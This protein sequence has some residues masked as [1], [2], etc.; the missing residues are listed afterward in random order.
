MAFSRSLG[1]GIVLGVSWLVAVGCGDSSNKKVVSGGESGE[2]GEATT[3]GKAS[4]GSSNNAGKAGAAGT[5][6]T[7][8]DVAGAGGMGISGDAGAGPLGTA[9]A[10]GAA[11]AGAGGAAP[12]GALS[13]VYAC[14]VDD[15]CLLPGN[16]TT[17]KC[18]PTTKRCDDRTLLCET[19]HECFAHVDSWPAGCTINDDCSFG[20]A[21]VAF[22]GTGFCAPLPGADGC[23]PDDI[24]TMSLFEGG[25]QQVCGSADARCIAGACDLGCS[26][27]GCSGGD[28][29]T[30]EPDSGV[31]S[32]ETGADCDSGVC[33]AGHC[34]PAPQCAT[35]DDCAATADD[36]GLDV[37]VDGKCGC[38]TSDTCI[39]G[40][41]QN[42]S[43][44]CE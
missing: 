38:A 44:V 42:S 20:E 43:T 31:C 14:Q 33:T 25:E 22:R 23:A 3:G 26:A 24:V 9:G 36:T 41:F 18:N 8:A 12:A 19:D 17:Y 16:D 35:S 1:I 40:S 29:Q 13:C 5:A 10:G 6:G 11:E 32:C 15:D 4:G 30:C 7:V 2:G 21:C 39:A 28:G 34:E 27:V 37:C